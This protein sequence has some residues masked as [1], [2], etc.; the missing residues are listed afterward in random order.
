MFFP[1]LVKDPYEI[2]QQDHREDHVGHGV[3]VFTDC[4]KLCSQDVS[5]IGQQSSPDTR[6]YG[7]VKK[8]AAKF[9]LAIPAGIEI[10]ERIPGTNRQIRTASFPC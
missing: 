10:K 7:A 6:A 4:L 1:T 5:R 8:E 2:H 9:I 3:Q